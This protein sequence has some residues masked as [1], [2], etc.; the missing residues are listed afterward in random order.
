MDSRLL[1]GILREQVAS[2]A[3]QLW[4][5]RWLSVGLAWLVCGI[6]WP[7]IALIPPKYE[8]SARVYVNADGFLTPLLRG[9]TADVDPRRQLEFLQRTLLSRPNL[10]QVIHLSDLDLS[11]RGKISQ[12]ER[13]EMLRRLAQQVLIKAQTSNLITVS[14]QNTDPS[15]A[16]NV[17]QAFLTVFAE[18]SA[19]GNRKE[20]ENAKRFLDQQ[21]QTYEAQLRAAEQR[22]AEFREK[23]VEL[24]PG[25]DGAA[26]PP[27]D[28]CAAGMRECGGYG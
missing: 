24:L 18:N 16:K 26:S 13:E 20:V 1:N 19:G 6:G 9:L 17:V 28:W 23:Y 7:V 27:T 15:I 25:A 22:R 3:R 11:T 8:V 5:Y 21:I 2:Y 12:K 14:Y 10:E 4:R